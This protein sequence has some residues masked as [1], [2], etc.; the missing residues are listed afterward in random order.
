[1]ESFYKECV[2]KSHLPFDYGGDLESV[3]TL[4]KQ[5]RES[6]MKLRNYFVM[7]EQQSN[8]EFDEYVDEFGEETLK[9]VGYF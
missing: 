6:L 5:N 3:E 4:H 1:M 7:E 8:F 2:P 9:K